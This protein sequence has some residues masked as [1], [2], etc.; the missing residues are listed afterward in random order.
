VGDSGL[1]ADWTSILGLENIPNFSEL[2]WL[3]YIT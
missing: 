3:G 1:H 2:A